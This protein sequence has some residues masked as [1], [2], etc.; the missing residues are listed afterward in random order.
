MTEVES[1]LQTEIGQYKLN[2]ERIKK[3]KNQEN[4]S[5]KDELLEEANKL[6][7][8]FNAEKHLIKAKIKQ[9]LIEYCDLDEASYHI[10]EEV[11][12]DEYL[13]ILEKEL[14]V[15]TDRIREE[16]M[17]RFGSE[18]EKLQKDNEMLTVERQRF[19]T[20]NNEFEAQ[21]AKIDELNNEVESHTTEMNHKI[22][23]IR[24]LKDQLEEKQDKIDELLLEIDVMQ[25]EKI[26]KEQH[27]ELLNAQMEP[28]TPKMIESSSEGEYARD[29]YKSDNSDLATQNQSLQR[30]IEELNALIKN[31][32][33][34]QLKTDDDRQKMSEEL[35]QKNRSLAEELESRNDEIES[36]KNSSI[37]GKDGFLSHRED[38]SS[39]EV[40]QSREIS[41]N[42]FDA[43]EYEVRNNLDDNDD[44]FKEENTT[45]RGKLR[46][47]EEELMDVQNRN[48]L[49]MS[50]NQKLK[51]EVNELE[52]K[53]FTRLSLPSEGESSKQTVKDIE[54]LKDILIKFLKETPM[55]LNRG[56]ENLLRIVFSMLDIHKPLMDEV[57]Q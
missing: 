51:N 37:V 2:L 36:M 21:K 27:Q 15:F 43:K 56:N 34:Q 48:N 30:K 12:M 19:E 5:Q 1:K 38:Y 42:E 25:D 54:H 47:L 16:S 57:Q 4:E 40:D 14:K 33:E 23:E 7:E 52:G 32:Q 3:E 45:L 9:L 39:K 26:E 46:E 29:D 31:L 8:D 17:D 6:L 55:S 10:D 11:D 22:I 49:I 44:E 20:Q 41:K 18:I 13:E 24:D 50:Q 35:I 28:D 53:A